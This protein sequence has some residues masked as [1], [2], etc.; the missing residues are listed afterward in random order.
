MAMS[1]AEKEYVE[2]L[3]IQLALQHTGAIAPDV[4]P[5]N[6]E[7]SNNLYGFK[8]GN[9]SVNWNRPMKAVTNRVHHGTFSEGNTR[10]LRPDTQGACALYSS[11]LDALRQT[12]YNLEQSAAAALRQIDLEIAEE[13]AK[14]TPRPTGA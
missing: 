13:L 12:R 11:R 4:R 5:L 8:Q 1:K 10:P 6:L 2:Q 7:T 9:A 3:E 14:P